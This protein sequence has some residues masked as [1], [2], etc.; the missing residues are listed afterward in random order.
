MSSAFRLGVQLY[1]FGEQLKQPSA[2][3]FILADLA[4][5]GYA[6]VEGISGEPSELAPL[7]VAGLAYIGPHLVLP[8]LETPDTVG[9]ETRRLGGEAVVCSGLRQWDVR[10]AAAYREAVTLLNAAGQRLRDHGV[11]LHYHNHDFEFDRVDGSLT[12]MDLLCEGLDP[13]AVSLCVDTGW[14][15]RAG[16]DAAEFLRSHRDRIGLVHLRDFVGTQSVPLGQ[17]DVPLAPLIAL[18]PQLPHLR[19]AIVE[20][21]PDSTDAAGDSF[22]SRVFLRERFSL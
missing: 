8:A 1:V 7:Q 2:L 6:G 5:A 13:D 14:V 3:P 9:E 15:W 17:G 11:R 4:Q 21:D 19:W 10:D 12:G 20:Q 16:V 18:L 22:A